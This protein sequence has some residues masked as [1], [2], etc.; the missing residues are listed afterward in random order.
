MY[1]ISLILLALRGI[2]PEFI[3]RLTRLT[4]Q[5]RGMVKEIEHPSCGNMKLVN[6]PVKYSYSTPGI[7]SAPPTLGQHSEEVLMN[8]LGMSAGEVKA[9]KKDGVIA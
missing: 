7:R 6:T 2:L 5:A 3:T 4:A 8:I 1:A 9:L